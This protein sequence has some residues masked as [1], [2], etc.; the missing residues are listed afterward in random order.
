MKKFIN[1]LFGKLIKKA[2]NKSINDVM[3]NPEVPEVD[4]ITIP[5]DNSK[6][7]IWKFI[8][9]VV[10]SILT[11]LAAALTTTSCVNHF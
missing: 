4:P 2:I 6:K 1:K 10:I 9:Q 3:N 11:A 8:I 7:S 5:G